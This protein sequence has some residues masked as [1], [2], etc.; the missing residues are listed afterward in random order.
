MLDLLLIFAGRIRNRT[1]T[2]KKHW[3]LRDLRGLAE[4][5]ER[6]EPV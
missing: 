2:K 1:V 3:Q 5:A 4:Y 6:C